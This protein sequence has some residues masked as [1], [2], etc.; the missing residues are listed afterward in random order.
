MIRN[1]ARRLV[2]VDLLQQAGDLLQY[3]IDN[4]LEGVAEAQIA[5]EL[6][7]IRIAQRDPEAALRV[8][9]RTRLADLSPTLERQRRILEA[10][11]L[12]DAGREELAVDLL[13]LAHRTRRRPAARSTGSGRASTTAPPPS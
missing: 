2:D 1:L 13:S 12:I 9:N 8:L 4:R 6:A 10:K 5:A 3:Q 7:I 11:A